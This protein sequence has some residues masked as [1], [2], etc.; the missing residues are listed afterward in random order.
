MRLKTLQKVRMMWGLTWKDSTMPVNMRLLVDAIALLIMLVLA[1]GLVEY[2]SSNARLADANAIAVKR[3]DL[4]EMN[5]AHCLNGKS[6][7]TEGGMI[8]CEKAFWV[9]ISKGEK[10]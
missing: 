3:A 6:L 4:A 8:M 5:L 7:T 2:V 9:D 10:S 1:Y